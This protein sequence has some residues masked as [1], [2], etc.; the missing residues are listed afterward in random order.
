MCR[1]G[2]GRYGNTL[3]ECP[4][5]VRGRGRAKRA[6]ESDPGYKESDPARAPQAS[7]AHD[8]PEC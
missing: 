5:V 4:F 1:H 8:A 2:V 6:D 3:T 7:S